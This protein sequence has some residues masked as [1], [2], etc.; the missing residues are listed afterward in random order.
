M[1]K[2]FFKT[3]FNSNKDKDSNILK[4]INLNSTYKISELV[5][6][7]KN[8]EE[9]KMLQKQQQTM[10]SYNILL[11]YYSKN[12]NNNIINNFME[13]ISKLNKK[14]Y[15]CS[16]KYISTKASF[17]K[18]NDELYLNL[19]KQIDCY[20]EEIQRLNKK[21]VSLDIKENKFEIKKLTKELSENKE[22]V[23]NYEVKLKEKTAKEEKLLK[24]L[25]SYKRRIIF[26]KNKIN[27][28]LIAQN[29]GRRPFAKKHIQE[30]N[31]S[32]ISKNSS[33]NFYSR[34]RR[35]GRAPR[36]K[37]ISKFFS[38]TPDKISNHHK[39]QSF[40]SS[41]KT[42][43]FVYHVK[44]KENNGNI[45]SNNDLN[46]MKSVKSNKKNKINDN[47]DTYN[48]SSKNL[49]TLNINNSK[50]IFSDGEVE[51]KDKAII[52]IN[53][54]VKPKESIIVPFNKN[55][56]K[57]DDIENISI[58]KKNS[59]YDEINNNI[60]LNKSKEEKK[61]TPRKA[62]LEL[63]KYSPEAPKKIGIFF[64]KLN[65]SIIDKEDNKT[66]K[67][68]EENDNNKVKNIEKKNQNFHST[69]DIKSKNK[70]EKKTI[71]FKKKSNVKF[72][73]YMT[74]TSKKTFPTK[75]LFNL[76]SEKLIK[77]NLKKNS[78]NNKTKVDNITNNNTSENI[79]IN[80][81][82]NNNNN[83]I[84]NIRN[85]AL[86]DI[87]NNTLEDIEQ[88][89]LENVNTNNSNESI[90]NNETNT[91]NNNTIEDM[92]DSSNHPLDKIGKTR[93][94]M[95][96]SKTVK[97]KDEDI[98]EK[99]QHL[100][101]NT[102]ESELNDNNENYE[103]S[104]KY[105]AK[106]EKKTSNDYSQNNSDSLSK[107]TINNEKL[108]SGDSNTIIKKQKKIDNQ[109]KN[110]ISSYNNNKQNK[111]KLKANTNKEKQKFDKMKNEKDKN[112]LARILKEMNEDYNNE[113]EMLKTQEDQVKL[114]LNLIDLNNI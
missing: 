70:T 45:S 7:S 64:E 69:L 75:R 105:L 104:S 91:L 26:F 92:N 41:N 35:Y 87:N 83:I 4:D 29:A 24:E 94:R 25:E 50:S 32:I 17:N 51:N 71:Q 38:P 9:S 27:I 10:D 2:N 57:D 98:L 74:N 39:M 81:L 59:N 79:K 48:D 99:E 49:I 103:I 11:N 54:R 55:Y 95:I 12:D 60:N 73:K 21:L 44:D 106:V 56:N 111:N 61:M 52:K 67:E 82:D 15:S 22:K 28:N 108:R 90:H 110:K 96:K 66:K 84:D 85:K 78:N 46:N 40:I 43:N 47:N 18:L 53:R 112:E 86:D 114:M 37:K 1:A 101:F 65:S 42:I 107:G 36:E 58:I 93:Y 33:K 88:N 34:L 68:K 5:K 19:F 89:K 113:L 16:E 20:V 14:F 6:N 102:S 23:R 62:L 72:K 13:K 8:N 76:P 100:N 63:N 3:F 97:F 31:D 77:S 109:K 30:N 80:K